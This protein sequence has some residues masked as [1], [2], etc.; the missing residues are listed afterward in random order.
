MLTI[1]RSREHFCSRFLTHTHWKNVTYACITITA[2]EYHAYIHS[3]TPPPN[4]RIIHPSPNSTEQKKKKKWPKTRYNGEIVNMKNNNERRQKRSGPQ[5][6]ILSSSVSQGLSAHTGSS[7]ASAMFDP[8]RSVRPHNFHEATTKE[9]GGGVVGRARKEKKKKEGKGKGNEC[10]KH[11]AYRVA[12]GMLRVAAITALLVPSLLN[13]W[14][15]GNR[16]RTRER[17]KAHVS[18]VQNP[19]SGRSNCS[20]RVPAI[21][22]LFFFFVESGGWL[23]FSIFHGERKMIGR[24]YP[25][26]RGFS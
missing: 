26:R 19:P 18:L 23:F 17:Q 10:L 12:S 24:V 13:E 4:Q 22:L 5:F 15:G 6:S 1:S 8:T 9:R 7:A 16:K 14:V 3:R 20:T 21:Q 11:A 25:G 2:P